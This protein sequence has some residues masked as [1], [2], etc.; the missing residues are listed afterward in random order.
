M[1]L[2]GL[3][4]RRYFRHSVAYRV[5]PRFNL[6]Q[7]MGT[8]EKFLVEREGRTVL[9]LETLLLATN[10]QA[11][12]SYCRVVISCGSDSVSLSRS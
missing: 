9:D 7:T 10:L 2:I 6:L 4:R 1:V 12:D 3:A 11:S 5:G 8:E